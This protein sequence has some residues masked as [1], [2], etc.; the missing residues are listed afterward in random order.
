MLSEEA[1]Q[2]LRNRLQESCEETARLPL[3][4]AQK[5]AH[6][7]GTTLADVEGLALEE[8]IVPLRYDRNVGTLGVSGQSRLL[9]SKV[10]IV[11]LGG[12]GGHVLEAIARLGVGHVVGIDPDQYEETNLNRQTLATLEGLGAHKSTQGALRVACINP[13]VRFTPCARPLSELPDDVMRDCG[14]VFD[15]LDSV[16]ARCNLAQRCARL[17]LPLVHGAI[18][19]WNGHVAVCWPGSSVLHKLYDNATVGLEDRLGNLPCTA[20]VAANIMV[21]RAVPIL[22]GLAPSGP[23]SVLFFDL[24]AD[25]W[26]RVKL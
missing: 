25:E 8:G 26:E 5:M 2:R 12:L 19:G 13:A 20:A 23:D 18:A 4:Q 21:A 11:G 22:L 6:D 7:L 9:S 24:K 10:A 17:D 14:I 1:K 16:E 3:R 15:C